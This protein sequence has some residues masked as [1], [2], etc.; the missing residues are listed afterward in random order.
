MPSLDVLS[1]LEW[2]GI[3]LGATLVVLL[4]IELVVLHRRGK[5]DW[6]RARE[7]LASASP[8]VPT[9]LTEG[10][11]L[12]TFGGALTFVHELAPVALPTSW[13]TAV[14][15]FVLVDFLYYWDHRCGHRVRLY[16][17]VSHS[18]HHSSTV[19]DQTTGLRVSFVD[20]FVAALFYWPLAILG[21]EPTLVIA[22]FFVMVAYQQWLHTETIGKIAWMDPWLNTPSN[23]RVHHASQEGYID[24]NY[25]GVLMIW[26]RLFGTY[27]AE[28][29]PTRYGLTVPIGARDPWTVHVAEL[30]RLIRDLRRAPRLGDMWSLL[31][32]GPEWAPARVTAT[33]AR[34]PDERGTSGA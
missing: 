17:A 23:H 30:L 25:G 5:L 12:A 33:P 18:V 14:I 31:W 6:E 4:P 9:L 8:V 15:C 16:W 24:K 29:E 2:L 7:M 13:G 26:D 1:T 19:Y 21:F 20:G 28:D 34:E 32:R 27:A 11:A 10:V 3:A 22:C